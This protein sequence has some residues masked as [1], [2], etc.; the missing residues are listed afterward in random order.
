MPSLSHK[1][2]SRVL[3]RV[4]TF[5][6]KRGTLPVFLALLLRG[7]CCGW[8]LLGVTLVTTVVDEGMVNEGMHELMVD[9]FMDGVMDELMDGGVME[10]CLRG[11][12]SK[13]VSDSFLF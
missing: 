4:Y 7:A 10:G 1:S 2:L 5:L 6:K 11:G 9:G 3:A 8:S 12:A 13:E